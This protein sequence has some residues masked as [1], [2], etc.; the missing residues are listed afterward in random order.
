M[1]Q[2]RARDFRLIL[3]HSGASAALRN[4]GNIEEMFEISRIVTRSA[5]RLR[6][7]TNLPAPERRSDGGSKVA[8]LKMV[9][10][11]VAATLAAVL[12]HD[13]SART[14]Y[15]NR[16]IR[17]VPPS[18]PAGVHDIIGRLWVSANL[19]KQRPDSETGDRTVAI[20]AIANS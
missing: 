2:N 8:R 10:C 5:Q 1:R 4:S 15:P 12:A 14:D 6:S 19:A 20:N 16:P 17:L 11:A 9:R 18:P 3:I 13:A 7:P